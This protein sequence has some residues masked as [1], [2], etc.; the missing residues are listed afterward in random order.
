VSGEGRT[1]DQILIFASARLIRIEVKILLIEVAARPIGDRRR[2]GNL[3]EL[4]ARKPG[5]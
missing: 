5:G 4:F 2:A 1:D 3:G